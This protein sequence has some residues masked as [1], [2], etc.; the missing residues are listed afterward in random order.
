VVGDWLNDPYVGLQP[1]DSKHP[2]RALKPD[3]NTKLAV[4]AL[5]L[6]TARQIARERTG[7]NRPRKAENF[8]F[9]LENRHHCMLR[10]LVRRKMVLAGEKQVV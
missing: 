10:S 6:S 3:L 9:D 8:L 1:S 4:I 5:L 7:P 2:G